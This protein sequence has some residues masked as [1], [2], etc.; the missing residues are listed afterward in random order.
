MTDSR[1]DTAP[2]TGGRR[3]PH[4]VSVT[5]YILGGLLAL[6]LLLVLGAMAWLSTGSGR[7]FVLAQARTAVPGLTIEGDSG[8]LFDLRIDRITLADA[9]GVWLTVEGAALDW[10]PLALLTR[11]LEINRLAADRVA[12]ARTPESPDTPQPEDDT[13]FR[14]PVAVDL[15][16]LDLPRIELGA[17]LAGGRPAMG[18]A[19]GA[20][21][22]P[23]GRP[24]GHVRLNA[25]RTDDMP[26]TAVLDATY[27]PQDSLAL[28]LTLEE[29]VGGLVA[30]LLQIPGRP[31]V[32][33]TLT[34]S[35]PLTDWTGRLAA[36]AGDVVH[37]T[38]EARIRPTADRFSFGLEGTG[39]IQALLP[40]PLNTLAGPEVAF[41]AGGLIVPGERI[42][43]DGVGF[44]V[45][46]GRLYGG[47]EYAL[48]TDALNLGLVFEAPENSALHQV[49]AQPGFR[50]G[51]L[52]LQVQGTSKA[53][54]FV[55]SLEIQA[56]TVQSYG[57][58]RLTLTARAVP[59]GGRE[60]M[61]VTAE[62]VLEQPLAGDPALAG[63][64]GPAPVLSLEAL[65]RSDD[66]VVEIGRLALDAAALDLGGSGTL[67]DWGRRAEAT[68]R[69]DA[70]DLAP[71]SR[72]AG[73][74]GAGRDLRGAVT[75]EIG[76]TRQDDTLTARIDASGRRLGVGIAAA[77]ALLGAE[78]R[79]TGTVE[80]G[81]ALRLHDLRLT[82]PHATIDGEASLEGDR[83]R[84]SSRA[85]LPD[86]APLA[87]ALR[88]PMAG[89]A[90]L[91]LRAEGP[92]EALAV[93]GTLTGTGLDIGGRRLGDARLTAEL[94]EVPRAPKGR[95]TAD[96]ALSQRPVRLEARLA[97]G[98]RDLTLEDLLLRIGENRVSGRLAADLAT[99]TASGA[100]SAALPDLAAIGELAGQRL[101]GEATAEIRLEA[102]GGRQ[103]VILEVG[104]TGL[105]HRADMRAQRLQR[106]TLGGRITDLL[107][108]PTLDLRAQAANGFAAGLRLERVEAT[109]RGP[110]TNAALGLELSGSNGRPISLSAAG[111]L[112]R[113]K[114]LTTLALQRFSGSIDDTRFQ[115]AQPARLGFGGDQIQ[116]QGLTLVS[117][118]SR[119][120][121]SAELSQ[122]RL[123]AQ[124]ELVRVP[125]AWAQLI[126]PTLTLEGEL[127]G[128]ARLD[129][130]VAAPR[131]EASLRLT[132][133]RL[134][135]ESQAGPSALGASMNA[136]W[137]DGRVEADLKAEAQGGG[138][139]LN[140][141][142]GLPLVLAGGP[143]A[144][145]LPPDRP[146]N[147]RLDGTVELV[148][149]N[150]LL[151]TT[152]DRLGGR[153]AVALRLEGSMADQ[154]LAGTVR[155]I[156]ASYENQQW[157][158]RVTAITGTLAGGPDG[159]VVQDLHG[160][161]PGD[162]RV[163]LEGAIRFNPAFGDRQID[164][165][166]R[167][168]K[169]RVAQT[170]LV[171]ATADADV[172]V[173]GSF[174]DVLVAGQ[175]TVSQARVN[176][177]DRLP[178][179]VADL[180]VQ[181]VNQP[182]QRPR[183][184]ERLAPGRLPP[185]PART[186]GARAG[187]AVDEDRSA[188]PGMVVALQL[189]VTAPNQI[190]VQGRGL[191]AEFKADLQVRGTA[192]Q[193]LVSGAVT[194][195]KGEAAVLGQTFS[196]SR[197]S[198]TFLGDGTLEPALDIEATTQRGDLTA[199]IDVEGRPSKPVV[200]LSS[201]PAYPEDEVLARLLFNRG[202][203]Q[204]SAFE[205]VQLAQSAAQLTGL[206]GGGPGLM[207]NVKRSLGVDR[208]EIR[209]SETGEGL[210]T[211]AAGRYIGSKVYVGV[212]QELGTGQSKAT[213]EY[214]IT[215]H[216]KA[217]G[218]VGTE[219]Q[220]GV[221][222]EWDY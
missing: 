174:R 181:E 125:L 87:P 196:L 36:R 45:A 44:T 185:A 91:E 47:G 135:P 139:D 110:L 197:A 114:A 198:F 153:M 188:G 167:A 21:E 142:V 161:T 41:G 60:R 163:A 10:S 138:V 77:D 46:A 144:F 120:A 126:D 35:G 5:L 100:L 122:R 203:G 133:F 218:E 141:H 101:S 207:D 82:S 54:Q 186:A 4:P 189:D 74:N 13:P 221:Q 2:E 147:G 165:R 33:V 187:Q 90:T 15:E 211:V 3:L 168:D 128:N 93:T 96:T 145:A 29:P 26:G 199:I 19:E 62:A 171:T 72:L 176:I 164:L 183:G 117:G 179:S 76:L 123:Q 169:A 69:L 204:L 32:T 43:L 25:A 97:S 94:T 103:T 88:Q 151:A 156:E 195:V 9:R 140:G 155:L 65:V 214:G 190:Y 143:L 213:V 92:L 49:L 34:G 154:R 14:L 50:S 111:T 58:D 148:R 130:S 162:G 205:A 201:N 55:S 222:V 68:L 209:S 115:L 118:D 61:A 177:P 6:T 173:A 220:V 70:A 116:V 37:A 67:R 134:A 11:T 40:A 75:A 108:T 16:R 80:S 56:P 53:P 212:E 113:D 124:A 136:V 102:P 149:L 178:A 159:L 39:D 129:G 109:A 57:A 22:I 98:A 182:Q 131:G 215:D 104:A 18:K 51:R 83:L 175:A 150:D 166:L 73:P 157:G 38:A 219:S 152:G 172:S 17:A 31:P 86:L 27:V 42:A 194:L 64:L 121:V 202:A 200:R 217:R 99:G 1:P 71:L 132:R 59:Q 193:P 106:L 52:E 89:S 48:Q 66:A 119:V 30:D 79:L 112:G 23:A 7:G 105:E 216:I 84:A 160:S 81:G 107:G 210:G 20:A 78:T 24:G 180:T 146:V 170:D 208:L 127:N 8:S 192:E 206:I 137:R 63:L 95:I 12:V 184:A 28:N 158:T 85:T 191:D